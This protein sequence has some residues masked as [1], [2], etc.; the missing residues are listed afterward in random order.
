MNKTIDHIMKELKAPFKENELEFRV[1]ATNKDKSMGLALAYVEARAIQNRLDEVVGFNNWKVTYREVNGGFI[2]SMSLRID[3]EW[4]SKEDGAQ[5]TD[6]ES[7]KGGI[8]SAFKR[9]ASSGWGI[10]R[11]LY[12]L[13]NNWFPIDQ[14]GKG[15][16]FKEKSVMS[17]EMGVSPKDN[18]IVKPVSVYPDK[19]SKKSY[20]SFR[21]NFGKYKGLALEEIYV[22]DRGYFMWLLNNGKSPDIVRAC[23]E[24]MMKFA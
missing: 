4:V 20:E 9:V 1:G 21:L 14:R 17:A 24:F 2:C 19:R 12:D 10:G 16:R 23:K 7:V 18:S 8:S 3:S 5:N 22:K 11:Y 15:Y 6:Y 13:K